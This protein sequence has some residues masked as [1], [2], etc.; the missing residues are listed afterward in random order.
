MGR[1]TGAVDLSDRAQANTEESEWT[2]PLDVLGHRYPFL[3][4]DRLR[5]IEPGKRALGLKR[6]ETALKE[7]ADHASRLLGEHLIQNAPQPSLAPDL[8][9]SIEM[10]VRGTHDQVVEDDHLRPLVTSEKQDL[11]DLIEWIRR[12]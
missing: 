9:R 2:D 10:L 4:V 5:V 11:G 8:S 3:L 6:V 7:F 12:N 1:S